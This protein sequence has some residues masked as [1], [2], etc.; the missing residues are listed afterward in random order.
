VRD[1]NFGYGAKR[2]VLQGVDFSLR[3]GERVAVFGGHGSGK[4]SL[5]QLL[6][7]LR[8][9]DSGHLE[10]DGLDLGEWRLDA[11]RSRVA[12]VSRVEIVEDSLLENVRLGRAEIGLDEVWRALEA[13][14][15]LQELALSAEALKDLELGPNGTPLSHAQALRLLLARAMVGRPGLLVLDGSLD[16][17]DS[18][19]RERIARALF[20]EDAPWTLLVLTRSAQVAAL[21]GRVVELPGGR[22]HG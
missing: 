10:L 20:A 17:M 7:G 2:P 3:P 21:C 9:T 19:A 8:Q 14:G 22:R 6:A 11:L 4:S 15:L 5:A 1:L 12:L 18:L 16:E 13:V